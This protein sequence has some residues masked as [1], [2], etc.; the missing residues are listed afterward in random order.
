M[1]TIEVAR[2]TLRQS[3]RGVLGWILAMAALTAV[4]TSSYKSVGAAKSAA[5]NGYPDALKKAFNLQDFTSPAGYLGSTVFGIPLVLL[6]TVYVIAAGTRAIAGDEEAKALDLLLSYPVSRATVV[7]ARMLAIAAVVAAQGVA[8]LAVLVAL[9]PPAGLHIGITDLAA[10]TLTWVLLGCC[11]GSVALL[12]S[13]VS[14]RRAATLGIG[15]AAA[16]V[17]YLAA[18]LL[19]LIHGLGWVRHLSPYG[20]FTGGEPLRH[21]LQ[22][23]ECGLLLVTTVTATALAVAA[24]DRRDIAV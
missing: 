3:R 22:P 13:A 14:G 23:G 24:L 5:I 9:A 11:L 7:L 4:Y 20:W 12:V 21:G 2:W 19:P 1:S 10:T 15:A 18:G 16:L 8:V 6:V 17:A